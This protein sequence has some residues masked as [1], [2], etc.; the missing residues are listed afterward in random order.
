VDSRWADEVSASYGGLYDGGFDA[1]SNNYETVKSDRRFG[2]WFR[3]ADVFVLS[4]DIAER[5]FRVL[6]AVAN[7]NDIET[8]VFTCGEYPVT[9]R[10]ESAHIHRL[11]VTGAP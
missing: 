2:H 4:T 7:N 10:H 11:E 8:H 6:M 3:D 9:S 5:D 1:G